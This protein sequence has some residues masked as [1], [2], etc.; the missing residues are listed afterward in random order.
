VPGGIILQPGVDRGGLRDLMKRRSGRPTRMVNRQE[1]RTGTLWEGRYRYSPIETDAYLLA[2]SRYVEL[3]PVPA[4]IIGDPTSYP[5]SSYRR[6]AGGAG[7]YDGLDIDPCYEGLGRS[8]AE[9]ALRD[10]EFVCGAVAG[11]MGV[12]S[13]GVAEWATDWNQTLCRRS[14]NP[15]W[16]AHRKQ[17]AGQT[18]TRR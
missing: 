17:Q 5:W 3:N 1:S 16:A 11:R 7:E 14:R 15:H 2:C 6:H 18:A 9:R 10:R 8:D 4:G 12:H 13:R